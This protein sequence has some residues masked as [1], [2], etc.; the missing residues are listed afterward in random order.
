MAVRRIQAERNTRN[1]RVA[2]YIRVSTDNREQDE[3]YEAQQIYYEGKIKGTPCWD[4][5]G[6]YGDWESGTHADKRNS[7]TRW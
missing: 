2:A 7:S 4:F 1:L 3:S 5:A 6:V